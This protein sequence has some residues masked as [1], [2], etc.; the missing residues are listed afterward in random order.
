MVTGNKLWVSLGLGLFIFLLTSVVAFSAA[1]SWKAL[2]FRSFCAA[3]VM[4]GLA[5]VVQVYL[6]K[7]VQAVEQAG[8]GEPQAENTLTSG[9]PGSRLD[10]AVPGATP[11]VPGQVAADLE[12]LLA[13]DPAR[14]AEIMR[15]M[16]L[17]D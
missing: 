14:A 1:V 16:Q 5:L 11:F 8:L 3:L 12:Q 13:T 10:V 7:A 17:E 15:K 4:G 6:E 2:L 9:E